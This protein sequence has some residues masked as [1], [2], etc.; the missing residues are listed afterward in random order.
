MIILA[1]LLLGVFPLSHCSF[2]IKVHVNVTTPSNVQMLYTKLPSHL[3]NFA[4]QWVT[5]NPQR[6][7]FPVP[8]YAFGVVDCW[9]T[10]HDASGWPI[11]LLPI[12][13]WTEG[14]YV[15]LNVSWYGP[16]FTLGFGWSWYTKK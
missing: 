15:T 5:D 4:R 6:F 16:E 2:V 8:H 1:I 11:G 14:N 13:F 12:T 10:A 7:G 9:V 3:G